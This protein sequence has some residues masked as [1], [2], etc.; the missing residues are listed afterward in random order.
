MWRDTHN[1]LNGEREGWADS[2]E[3]R[4]WTVSETAETDVTRKWFQ[5]QG[6]GCF[7]LLATTVWAVVV[8]NVGGTLPA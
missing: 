8:S 1:G 4:G 3:A 7:Q 6:Q 2:R 5:G